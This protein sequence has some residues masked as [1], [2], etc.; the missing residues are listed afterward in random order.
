MVKLAKELLAA[1]AVSNMYV[2]E[3]EMVKLFDAQDRRHSLQCGSLS[4]WGGKQLASQTCKS[5]TRAFLHPRIRLA[6]PPAPRKKKNQH[7]I[8]GNPIPE[9]WS[10]T[11]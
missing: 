2:M 4:T 8:L 11:C 1:K 9:K 10:D 5:S 6:L 3:S 7:M